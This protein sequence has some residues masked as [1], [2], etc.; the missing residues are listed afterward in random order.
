MKHQTAL[1]CPDCENER[2]AIQG[3]PKPSYKNID[4][5]LVE[6][7]DILCQNHPAPISRQIH[8]SLP[9]D[10]QE[11]CTS[12]CEFFKPPREDAHAGSDQ[13]LRREAELVAALNQV[14]AIL[15]K[16]SS[17][18]RQRVIAT[19]QTHFGRLAPSGSPS[20][21]RTPDGSIDSPLGTFSEDRSLSSKE[22]LQQK[23]PATDVEKVACLAYYL[24]HYRATPHFKT[25]DISKLNTEAAQIK[26]SNAAVAVNNAMKLNYLT[27]VGKG[28]KQLT[29]FG[30]EFVLALPNRQAARLVMA[31]ARRRR[32]KRT[33]HIGNV[34][35]EE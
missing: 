28:A 12:K 2:I 7:Y 24:T 25:L 15:V 22:F 29:A 26:F 30:E 35:S 3:P 33:S 5:D 1:Y 6:H 13:E 18:D 21:Q 31:R 11:P 20:S 19:V 32:T 9:D 27:T 14:L 8:R 23:K 10:R 4:G 16:L 34:D 17:H